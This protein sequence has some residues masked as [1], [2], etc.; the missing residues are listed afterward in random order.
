MWDEK[1]NKISFMFILSIFCIFFY[2]ICS[3][4]ICLSFL[5]FVQLFGIFYEY[6]FWYLRQV[7]VT[8]HWFEHDGVAKRFMDTMRK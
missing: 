3:L 7:C 5:V 6:F 8:L 1:T 4:I 2:N